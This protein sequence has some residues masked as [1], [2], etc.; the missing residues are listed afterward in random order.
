VPT[1]PV[2]TLIDDDPGF[3]LM[4]RSPRCGCGAG[5]TRAGAIGDVSAVAH[6]SID[7]ALVEGLGERAEVD[8]LRERA[9]QLRAERVAAGYI[10]AGFEALEALPN[11]AII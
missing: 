9:E 8:R 11:L 6:E 2:F 10:R 1:D 7:G 4:N 5:P 3:G